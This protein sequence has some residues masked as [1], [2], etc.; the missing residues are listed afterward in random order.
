MFCVSPL[1]ARPPSNPVQKVEAETARREQRERRR[2]PPA[3]LARYVGLLWISFRRLVSLRISCV[4]FDLLA[5]RLC[6]FAFESGAILP[7]QFVA[8]PFHLIQRPFFSL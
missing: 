4:V 2:I 3:A 5:R 1:V 7:F 8:L 6:Y